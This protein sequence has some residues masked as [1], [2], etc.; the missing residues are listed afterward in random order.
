MTS[1]APLVGELR[2]PAT[3]RAPCAEGAALAHLVPAGGPRHYVTQ[4]ASGDDG[5]AVLWEGDAGYESLDVSAPGPRHR[6][7]MTKDGYVFDD[8]GL[9]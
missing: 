1:A 9:K 7:S 8:S 6:L 4:I 2:V 5:V 3:L